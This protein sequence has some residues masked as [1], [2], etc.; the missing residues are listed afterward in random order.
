MILLFFYL[1]FHC[2][3]YLCVFWRGRVC[4][5]GCIAM[6]SWDSYLSYLST[7]KLWKLDNYVSLSELSYLLSFY[8]VFIYLCHLLAP[9]SFDDFNSD[10]MLP[11][12]FCKMMEDQFATSTFIFPC[13]FEE[14]F[15]FL[16]NLCFR[17]IETY[18]FW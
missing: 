10:E 2:Y 3:C 1:C 4:R 11:L 8:I 16:L 15:N 6:Y 18:A 7:W 14:D 9:L 13:N 5:L 17:D 12:S